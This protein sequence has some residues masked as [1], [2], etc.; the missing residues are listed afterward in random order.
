MN[1][2]FTSIDTQVEVNGMVLCVVT[3]ATVCKCE[4]PALVNAKVEVADV[5]DPDAVLIHELGAPKPDYSSNAERLRLVYAQTLARQV[6]SVQDT[7]DAAKAHIYAAKAWDPMVAL[8][9]HL[10]RLERPQ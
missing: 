10:A 6:A 7:I 8:N 9:E 1:I 5:L 2:E 4:V 3:R